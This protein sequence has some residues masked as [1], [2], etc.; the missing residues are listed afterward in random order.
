MN[1]RP[2]TL[3]LCLSLLPS[4]AFAA[5]GEPAISTSA[6]IS[7]EPTPAPAAAAAP[8]P[9][10]HNGETNIRP[11]RSVGIDVKFDTSGVGFDVA[12]PLGRRF[13]LRGGASFLNYTPSI[14]SDGIT[15]SGTIDFRTA[16]ASVDYYPFVG[17]FR[18]SPGLVFYNGLH[19]PAT[20][21]V[22]P[23]AGFTLNDQKYYAGP[24]GVTGSF[25][26]TFGNKVAPSL[27]V[28]WGNLLPRHGGHF[29]VPFE[30][31]AEFT[32]APK[33]A[34]NLTGSACISSPCTAANA[35]PLNSPLLNNFQGNQSAEA[36]NDA[37]DINGLKV[38][39]I[40]SI[41]LGYAF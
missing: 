41:G 29:S 17:S 18:I 38:F 13:N 23:G 28:G 15:Y 32:G 40:I 34:L 9:G 20:A 10:V 27:T 4:A 2:I 8:R 1:V 39:P 14:T 36:Q 25:D 33:I 30:I 6:E 16:E 22:A 37:N 31:G 19:I 7:A 12:T 24:N 3:V 21:S 35:F 11:F 26:A 5:T